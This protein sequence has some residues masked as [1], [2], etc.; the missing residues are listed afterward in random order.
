VGQPGIKGVAIVY[1]VIRSYAGPGA[2]ELF[3]LIVERKDEVEGLLRGV[4]GFVNYTLI[5]T[6]DGGATVT[7][8]QN[9]SG[10]DESM[11]VAR[12]WVA[13]NAA[14]L[15]AAAPTVTEGSVEMHLS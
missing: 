14:D 12:D 13:A 1:G 5:Q 8:C 11:Q 10:T 15:G 6:N 3:D 9:K 2:K 4:T 7:V